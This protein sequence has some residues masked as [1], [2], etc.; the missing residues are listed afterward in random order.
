M[1]CVD[2][3]PQAS[4]GSNSELLDI[5]QTTVGFVPCESISHTRN[6]KPRQSFASL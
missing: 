1:P 4:V 5:G 2:E 6:M 3:L